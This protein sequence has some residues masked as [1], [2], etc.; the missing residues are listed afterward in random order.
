M[1]N[2]K[3][4]CCK[5]EK[6]LDEFKET[7]NAAGYTKMC[8]KCLDKCKNYKRKSPKVAKS[9]DRIPWN[10]RE[11]TEEELKYRRIMFGFRIRLI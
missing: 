10:L 5:V 11:H 2:K 6:P 1:I 7:N 3:C 8:I 9:K 4:S